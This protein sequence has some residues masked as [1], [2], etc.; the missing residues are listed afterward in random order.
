MYVEEILRYAA[1]H[2]RN[3]VR[4]HG[5]MRA[6]RGKNRLEPVAIILPCIA[7]EFA[8][9]GVLAA[10]VGRHASTRFARELGQALSE[11]V[12]QLDRR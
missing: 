3:L 2:M 8:S 11:Q 6:K 7:G 12:L 5:R 9:A 4:P 10:L 1:E